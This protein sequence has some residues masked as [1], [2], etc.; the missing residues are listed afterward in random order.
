M[1]KLL[2][3]ILAMILALSLA[4][5]GDT[6]GQHSGDPTQR[7]SQEQNGPSP[8]ESKDTEPIESNEPVE[9]AGKPY[10]ITYQNA[11]VWTNSIG[12]TWVQTIVEI[13][14]TSSKNLYLSSGSYDLEDADGKLVASQSLVSCYPSVLAPGEKGYM[15]EETT[16]DNYDG[17]GNLTILP[18]PS[19][20]TAK[21]DLI[22]YNVTDVTISDDRFSGVKVL[23][24][25]ENATDEATDGMVYIAAF[26]YDVSGTPIGSAFTILMEDIEAGAKIGFELSGFSLPDDVTADAVA[27]TIV[28][29]YPFQFQF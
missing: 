16:L 1:K 11:K 21:V 8:A 14:N 24:R 22:R 26:F 28:Y 9:P 27:N 13:T 7:P 2:A 23:G 18:R 15:Y 6:G 25:V 20:D 19:I 10:E 29:A 5:C 17:D 12:T 4:A 3:L